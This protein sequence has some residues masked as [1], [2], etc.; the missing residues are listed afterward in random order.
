[1]KKIKLKLP[2]L[3]LSIICSF[4]AFANSAV[5]IIVSDDI[6]LEGNSLIG[7]LYLTVD[8]DYTAINASDRDRFTKTEVGAYEDV[9]VKVFFRYD[10]DI[11]DEK[12]EEIEAYA[13]GVVVSKVG[14]VTGD[15]D[16]MYTGTEFIPTDEEFS[17]DSTPS[18]YNVFDVEFKIGDKES[19]KEAGVYT[20]TAELKEK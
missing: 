4:S 3:I 12:D 17:V 7:E 5:T 19:Q 15:I 13:V 2:I 6:V 14:V 10:G 1:M 18:G 9:G 16:I 8:D 20:V 11:P